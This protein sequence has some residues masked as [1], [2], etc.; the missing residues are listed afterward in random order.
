[1]VDYCKG[2]DFL[3]AD[4]TSWRVFDQDR[5]QHW[6]WVFGNEK[7][8]AYILDPSR[9]KKVPTEFL[10]GS[11]LTLLTDRY[12]SYKALRGAIRKAYCSV[13]LRRDFFKIFKGIKKLKAW[14]QAWLKLF[15]QLFGLN[16][17][18]LKLMEETPDHAKEWEKAQKELE[19]KLDEMKDRF[20]REL[21]KKSLHEQQ[22]KVLN[23]L[24][25][26]WSG[27]TVFV[28]EPRVPMDNNHAER[29]LRNLVVIRKNSYG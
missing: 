2:Q 15:G 8:A 23:S 1:I 27:L 21:R 13:H 5:V 16:H 18:R 22:R 3:N 29:L 17:A 28:D 19:A 6:F 7:V 9:S 4:E 20:Q 14:A 10:G 25:R 24:E 12:S 11:T 26:H